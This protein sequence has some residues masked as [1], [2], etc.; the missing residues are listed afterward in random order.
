MIV[1][2]QWLRDD[3]DWFADIEEESMEEE[4]IEEEEVIEEEDS[5]VDPELKKEFDSLDGDV[6]IGI[7][8]KLPKDLAEH[9]MRYF[10]NILRIS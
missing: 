2:Y 8:R 9:T 1:Y 3:Y 4:P 10:L 6:D 5:E 7:D